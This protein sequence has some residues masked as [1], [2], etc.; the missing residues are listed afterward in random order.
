MALQSGDVVRHRLGDGRGD[1][2][3]VAA[4][5]VSRVTEDQGDDWP[6][7]LVI[8]VMIALAFIAMV[9]VSLG[10]GALMLV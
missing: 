8:V 4:C 7:W 2:R 1:G 6:P 5:R 3:G 9:A 10:I